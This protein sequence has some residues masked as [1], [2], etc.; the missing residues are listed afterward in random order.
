[1]LVTPYTDIVGNLGGRT[2]VPGTYQSVA[3]IGV[4]GTLKLDAKDDLNPE[5]T[6]NIGAA[7][8]TAAASV[9]EIINPANNTAIVNWSI[10]GAVTLGVDS[11]IIGNMVSSGLISAG[12]RLSCGNLT[13]FATISVGEW[14]TTGSLDA[15]GDVAFGSG[16]TAG[17]IVAVGSVTFGA[18]ATATSATSTSG[19]ITLG[20]SASGGDLEAFGDISMGAESSALSGSAGGKIILSARYP[21]RVL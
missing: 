3:A 6:F 1:M 2:L 18:D 11:V 9:V 5:W 19:A 21:A 20:A 14:A 13:A 7:L 17:D 12:A 16:A 8:T 15:G 10:N 4:T